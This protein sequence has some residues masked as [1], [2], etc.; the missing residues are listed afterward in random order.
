MSK[1][2]RLLN[3]VA[4]LLNT[5]RPLPREE[6]FERMQGAY[7]DDPDTARRAF[8]RDK[9]E[10]KAL[11]IPIEYEEILRSE[12]AKGGYRIRQESFSGQGPDLAP[13][14]LSA[15]HVA[16]NLVRLRADPLWPLGGDPGGEDRPAPV[17]QLIGDDRVANLLQAVAER[18]EVT[19]RYLDAQRVLQPYRLSFSRGRWYLSGWDKDREAERRFRVDRIDGTVQ[20]GNAE[21][22]DRPPARLESNDDQPWRYGSGET[23]KAKMAVDAVHAT[24]VRNFL[25][26]GAVI[27]E[28][29]DGSLLVEE[30]VV[31]KE[32]F[33]SFVLTFLDGAEILGP[34]ELRQD[35]LDWL[36]ALQ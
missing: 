11:G 9:D 6:L 27:E 12:G 7:S 28:H 5:N 36:E 14:E 1:L 24:W 10:L 21:S 32:A 16:A 29:A 34:Q 26:E 2:E 3:L 13:D 8:E 31:N 25:G 4:A 20:L 33:R 19:F 17:A 22:F 30:E 18:H 23:I 15:L 35:M